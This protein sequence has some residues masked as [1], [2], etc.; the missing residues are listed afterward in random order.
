MDVETRTITVEEFAKELKLEIL[1]AGSGEMTFTTVNVS[2]PGLQLAGF[3]DYFGENRV[4]VMGNAE[5]KYYNAKP[6]KDKVMIM[7][8]IL[9]RRVP[10]TI[11]SRSL[12][13]PE[14]LLN[15]YKK[16]NCPLF[17]SPLETTQLVNNL[18]IFLNE[19]LAPS[20]RVHGVFVDVSGVGVLLTGKSGIGKSETALE[21]IKRGHRLVADDSIIIKNVQNN[22]YGESPEV[23]RYFMEL[24]GI[25]I[26]DTRNMYGVTAIK[27]KKHVDLVVEMQNLDPKKEYDRLDGEG[28]YENILGVEIPKVIIPIVPGRNLPV[29]IEAAAA[30]F[31]LKKSGYNAAEVLVERSIKNR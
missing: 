26:I 29:I 12:E 21:L 16:H 4:Q 2:R 8:M 19:F 1:F 18:T 13:V 9:E 31:L 22:L 20:T 28:T 25:G 10:C 27:D 23:I 5:M 24:R 30:N 17:L 14:T 7:D 15:S 11:I 3:F 6:E